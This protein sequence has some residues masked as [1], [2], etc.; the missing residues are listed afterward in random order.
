MEKRGGTGE[1]HMV[2]PKVR[3]RC[4]GLAERDNRAEGA[5]DSAHQ[6]IIPMVEGVDG[7]GAAD[8]ESAEE[9]CE[10]EDHLPV[11]RVVRTHD[12]ELRV[13]VEGE[14]EETRPCCCRVPGGHRLECVVN[15]VFVSR[16]DG[17]VVHE[18]REP[19]AT[20]RAR[21][22]AGLANSKEVR[23]EATDKPFD[24]DLE[25]GSG[26]QALEQA[27]GRGEE[28]VHAA[29]ADLEEDEE[30]EGDEEGDHGSGPDGYDLLAE[31]VC[32]LWPCNRAIEVVDREGPVRGGPCKLR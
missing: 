6:E 4:K 20:A 27:H 9:R 3:H 23:A 21:R 12:L 1:Q 10:E 2:E 22:D 25:G 26:D 24:E 28:V 19:N 29:S 15:L 7:E 5:D 18:V 17:T 31:R 11:C 14:I 8:K 16:A 32:N 30:D 13:E